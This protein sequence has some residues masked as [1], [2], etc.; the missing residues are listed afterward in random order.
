MCL[1]LTFSKPVRR[2]RPEAAPTRSSPDV[3]HFDALL[4]LRN[5]VGTQQLTELQI[6]IADLDAD[7]TVSISDAL[8]ILRLSTGLR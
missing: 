6:T 4:A 3:G 7:G 5:S 8:N 1:P 2:E